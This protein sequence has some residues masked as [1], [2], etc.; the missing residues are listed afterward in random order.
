MLIDW[1][2]VGAQALNFIVLVWL[3]KRLLYKP[4]LNAVDARERRIAAELADAELKKAEALA[5]RDAFV[6]RNEEFD[7]ERE[8]LRRQAREEADAERQRLLSAARQQADVMRDKCREMLSRDAGSLSQALRRRAQAEVFDIA[9]KALRDLAATSLEE[10]MTEVFTQ[11]LC[12]MEGAAR[13]S[14]SAALAKGSQPALLRSAFDLPP[15]QRA[16]IEQAIAASFPG[17]IRLRFETV[18]DL[19]SGIELVANGLKVGWSI[20]DYLLSMEKAVDALLR[21][22][23][24]GEAQ[25]SAAGPEAARPGAGR[26]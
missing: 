3:L 16:V 5:Q 13:A 4:I 8:A 14:L 26:A 17:E 21:Q 25:L 2:T 19:V 22:P 10:R 18:P 1:F 6:R 11:R 12:A 24:G 23:E 9:R 15:A 7:R 20:A